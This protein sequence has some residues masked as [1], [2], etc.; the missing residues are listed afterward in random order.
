MKFDILFIMTLFVAFVVS[1]AVP[2]VDDTVDVTP[3]D[4]DWSDLDFLAW[5]EADEADDIDDSDVVARDEALSN[6]EDAPA[7]HDG[8]MGTL[9]RRCHRRCRQ[10]SHCCHTDVCFGGVC[11]GPGR[12]P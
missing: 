9:D 10:D 1:A 6:S 7:Y 8:E 3:T 11:I 12:Y 5:D 4:E 2:D